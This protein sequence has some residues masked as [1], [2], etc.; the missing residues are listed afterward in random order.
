[1][2]LERFFEAIGPLAN[3]TLAL[4]IQLPPSLHILEG[5]QMLRDLVPRLDNRF[6]YAVEVRHRSWFQDLAY[7]FF[8]NNDICMVWSQLADLQTP[9]ILTTDFLYLRF[10]GD[11]SIHENDFG[12]IQ[13]D[14]VLEMEKW[15][16]NIKTVEDERTKLAI[17]A[18]N[19]HYAGF[20]PAG[21]IYLG[22]CWGC[23][24]PSGRIE[25]KNNK[26]KQRMTWTQSKGRFPI[27]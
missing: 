4:L 13:L 18:A 27:S 17:I 8:A 15:A 20:G 23:Q 25:E 7:N 9:P 2:E 26:K 3:K 1:K 12:R 16:E 6:R 21:L 11:R 22:I 5:L 10:I 24:K 19:N 14:R